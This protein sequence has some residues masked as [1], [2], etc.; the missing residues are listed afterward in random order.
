MEFAMF[1]IFKAEYSYNKFAFWGVLAFVIPICILEAMLADLPHFYIVIA[2][3]WI[4]LYWTMTRNKE[5]R[6]YHFIRLPLSRWKLGIARILILIG[7]VLAILAFYQ[8]IHFIFQYRGSANYP[9]SVKY[10]LFYLALVL[11]IFSLYFIVRDLALFFLRSN[12]F[13]RL[14]KEQSKTILLF[15]ALVL[16]ILGVFAFIMRPTFIGKIFEF[17]IH[18]NPFAD[19]STVIKFAA[20][21]LALAALSIVT[22]NGK[23]TYLE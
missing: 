6:E 7:F 4:G 20:T 13:L 17:F 2:M 21:S 23:K 1:R 9:I 3:F 15:T 19:L 8:L 12:R 5:A 18:D 10:L 22:Y 11:F 16:N 14:S